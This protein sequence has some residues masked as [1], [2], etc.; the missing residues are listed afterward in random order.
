MRR[1]RQSIVLDVGAVIRRRRW[2]R[3][4]RGRRLC[5][6]VRVS[7]LVEGLELVGLVVVIEAILSKECVSSPSP[8]VNGR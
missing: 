1:V 4:E 8:T 7:I 3:R 6:E 2:A 5:V